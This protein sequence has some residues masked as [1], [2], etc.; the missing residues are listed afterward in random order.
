MCDTPRIYV[1]DLEAY[2][3]GSLHGVWIDATQDL[4]IIRAQISEMLKSSPEGWAEEYAIHDY[5]NF[6]NYEVEEYSC[7]ET[8]HEI[9]LFIEEYAEVAIAAL[10]YTSD[11]EDARDMAENRYHGCY[12]SEKEF[13]EQLYNDIYEIPAHLEYYI[14][15]DLIARDLFVN[16][17]LSVDAPNFQIHVFSYQ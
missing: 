17:Y 13:A 14:D 5:E 4:D 16:D 1:A 6:G 12:D 3:N 11:L 7:V 8:L 2:N 15:Y 10:E 9:A